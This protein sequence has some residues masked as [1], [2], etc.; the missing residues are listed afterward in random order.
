[1]VLHVFSSL[2]AAGNNAATRVIKR[3]FSAFP[4]REWP[5]SEIFQE[6]TANWFT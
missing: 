1:M 2:V 3:K 5:P 6:A 4:N